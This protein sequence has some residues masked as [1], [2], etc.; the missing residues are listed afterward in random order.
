LTRLTSAVPMADDADLAWLRLPPPPRE[1]KKELE[2]SL[3]Q[4][5]EVKVEPMA[6]AKP[7]V[8]RNPRVYG[9]LKYEAHPWP[10]KSNWV[11]GD[12]PP[13]ELQHGQKGETPESRVEPK[14]RK[15]VQRKVGVKLEVDQN[16]QVYV[17]PKGKVRPRPLGSNWVDDPPHQLQHHPRD[18]AQ[19]SPSH[20]GSSK[21]PRRFDRTS[22]EKPQRGKFPP[23]SSP[24]AQ[25]GIK[26][27]ERSLVKEWFGEPRP[28]S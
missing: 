27:F 4:Q 1:S 14:P 6:E 5:P 3:S 21:R 15:E 13:D 20:S 18:G 7:N 8:D 22:D 26:L 11:D 2:S 24:P 25:K 28:K 17:K 12:D 16:P 19:Q 23:R 10:Q 9:K